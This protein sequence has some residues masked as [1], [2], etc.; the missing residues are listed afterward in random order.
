M[1]TAR[2]IVPGDV[3]TSR[4]MSDSNTTQIGVGTLERLPKWMNLIPMIA[5]WLWLALIHRSLTLPS[6]A[7]P[8]LTCGG[9]VGDGKIEYFDMMGSA[10]RAV[11]AAYISVEN[12]GSASLGPALAAMRDAG[13]DFPVIAKP[14]L[15][16]CGFGVRLVRNRVELESYL[17]AYPRGERLVIQRFVTFEGEAGLYYMRRPGAARGRIEGL[18]LRSF[19]RVTGNGVHTI[20]QLMDRDLRLQRLGRDGQSEPC[21]DTTRIPPAGEV[22]RVAT[23]GSTRVGGLYCDGTA[24]VTEELTDALEYIARDMKDFHAGRFDIR[25]ESIGALRAGRGFVIIEVNGA[26]SE[27]VQAW[28]PGLS[29]RQAYR[30]VFEKQRRIFEIGNAMRRRGH[31]PVGLRE[32]ARHYF[33]QH[34]LI[35]RYP[36]SN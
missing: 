21:C 4:P 7:N 18:L 15:G 35:R 12:Q 29:L 8:G 11:T 25:Y 2:V 26:G 27:A 3:S 24:L 32:L 1:M 36:P 13:L 14:D 17:S 34:R 20:A 16:W 10:A 23:I 31:K 6:A 19:P 30:I 9:L 5:Q 28:D 33:R 22:V